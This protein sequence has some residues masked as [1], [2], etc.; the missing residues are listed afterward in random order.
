MDDDATRFQGSIPEFYDSGL[1]PVLFRHYADV[2]G[3]AVASTAP[4]RILEVA[5]GTGISS[6]GIVAH[7]PGAELVLTDLNEAM[8]LRAGAKV[9]AGTHIQVADAQALPF[10]DG[11]FDGDHGFVCAVRGED[12]Q[13]GVGDGGR[14]GEYGDHQQADGADMDR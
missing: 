2:L 11:V 1:G 4:R 14:G 3:E 10:D 5:A 12:V 9:P 8:L 7:N 13:R 6:A